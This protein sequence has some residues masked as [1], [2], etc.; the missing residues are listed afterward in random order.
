MHE[1]IVVSVGHVKKL[2]IMQMNEKN[3]KNNKL[4]ETL[5]SLD[6]L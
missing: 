4:I 5:G 1:K 3:G 2:G 6:C